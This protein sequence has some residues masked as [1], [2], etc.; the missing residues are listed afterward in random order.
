MSRDTS[1]PAP[2]NS[3]GYPF[4]HHIT[5]EKPDLNNPV[6]HGAP[7]FDNQSILAANRARIARMGE[8]KPEEP[9]PGLRRRRIKYP[10]PTKPK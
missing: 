8:Y 1:I 6:P 3:A 4:G 5:G 2:P 7:A 10:S 9:E